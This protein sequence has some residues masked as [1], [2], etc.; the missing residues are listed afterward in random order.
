MTDLDAIEALL[1]EER[2][3]EARAALEEGPDEGIE[4]ALGWRRALRRAQLDLRE[5]RVPVDETVLA[6]EALIDAPAFEAELPRAHALRI[7]GYAAKRCFALTERAVAEAREALGAHP[8]VLLSEGRAMM[9]FDERERAHACFAKAIDAGGEAEDAARHALA[10]GL[11]VL[12][13]FDAAIAEARRVGPGPTRLRALRLIASCHAARQDPEAEAEAWAKVLEE[14]EGS[15]HAQ[16]DRISHALAL[17]GTGRRADALEA[18][19]EAWRM[20]PDSGAG[21][22][23]RERMSHL[24]RHLEGGR[25]QRLAA[26]PTTSQKWNYC[27]P[28]VLE[29]CFRYLAI[30]LTQDEI[31][32]VVKRQHGTP[33]FEI[34]AFLR[35]HDIV[36]RR[37]E[38]TRARLMAAIDLGLPVI[39]QEEYSTTSH[40]AVLVGYDEA[41]GTFIAQDPATH[42]PLMKTFEFTAR[43]GQL[44]GNGA[45]IVLGRAGPE[46]AA[47]E[48]RCDQAGLIDAPHLR[49]LDDADRLRPGGGGAKEEASLFELLRRCDEAIALAP[50]FKL[51][52]HR[53]VSAR[54]RLH[55]MTGRADDRDAFL[56]DLHHVRTAFGEDEWPHQL[57]AHSLFDRGLRDEAYAEYLEASRRDP[58]DSHNKQSMGECMWLGGDLERAEG[59]LLEALALAPHDVRAAENLAA[60]YVRE[61]I[62][63]GKK[64]GGPE[65]LLA[66]TRVFERVRGADET[67]RRRAAHFSRVALSEHPDNPFDHEVAGDLAAACGDW[68]G[69]RAA[70]AEALER[71]PSSP[72]ASLGLAQALWSLERVEEAERALARITEGGR[73]PTRAF[74]LHAEALEALE[75]GPEAAEMLSRA[76][77]QGGEPGPLADALWD[78]WCRLESR[79]V[80]AAR[81]RELAEAHATDPELVRAIGGLLDDENQRGHAVSLFRRV[82]AASPQDVGAMSRLGSLLSRDVLT[83]AEGEATLRRVVELAPRHGWSRI[84][85]A[86]ALAERDPAEGLDHLDAVEDAQDPYVLE[87]R[88]ALSAA[89]GRED[90][91]E[92]ALGDALRAWADP[93]QGLLDLVTWHIDDMRYDRALALARRVPER[94]TSPRLKNRAEQ[95]WLAAHRLAG[96]V[97]EAMPRLR[98][99]C[100]DGVPAHL[101]W[102]VYWATRS[103]DHR[104]AGDA[105]ALEAERAGAGKRMTW[106]IRAAAERAQ[107]GEDRDLDAVRAAMSES[108]N[109]WAQLSYAYA[110]LDRYA[111]ANEAAE[112]AVAIDDTDEDALAAME[113]SWVRKGELEQAIACARRLAA[114]HPYQHIGPERLGA[115]LARAMRE[116]DEALRCSHHAVD[117]APF[118]HNAHWSRALALFATG[119][120]E[121]AGRHAERSLALH[122]PDGD[123]DPD[124]ALVVRYALAG[125]ADHLERCLER[126]A[127]RQPPALFA[128][129]DA[130]LRR[131]AKPR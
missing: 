6:V 115:L 102:D 36:A 91:A 48:A 1:A 31:A 120:L 130:E 13:D 117:A 98:A 41:L 108:A 64:T 39:V 74:T 58:G 62:E 104:L 42:R 126:Q 52:W 84:R 80:A 95:R 20:S 28:A 19:G 90:E 112:R 25:R 63:R 124:G 56:R 35:A 50:E 49:I 5:P 119:D 85:L 82:L 110:A 116:L 67:L 16:D 29:L 93:E 86:W 103:I 89:L 72:F 60:V 33:M 10:D 105:A 34:A 88:A 71:D 70:F 15:D 37:V 113:E 83:R 22:Y 40:V 101:A 107:L 118:C 114:I 17:A 47:L 96:A 69:A 57:H 8:R 4:T 129:F 122:E 61:L 128:A 123:D 78:L 125:Q 3:R 51:A 75:R 66:P 76:L 99:L 23:A 79:E 54:R 73:G 11:Y 100:E 65:S 26:F 9:G 87:T 106:R 7:D 2:I 121:G 43:A 94:V 131:V 12:G 55:Q 44:F 127:R 92:R 30:E 38:G 77:E 111:D 46:L 21:R 18:L 68:E 45:I 53:R 109:D 32:D 24:E 14:G 97:R 81:L 27:G 59:L